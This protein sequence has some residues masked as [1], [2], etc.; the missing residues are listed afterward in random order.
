MLKITLLYDGSAG[1]FHENIKQLDFWP[2]GQKCVHDEPPITKEK[3]KISDCPIPVLV[4]ADFLPHLHKRMV[5]VKFSNLFC[6][7]LIVK[8][9]LL[10]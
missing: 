1:I 9:I 7:I 10:H 5:A 6:K 4:M 3:I 8:L 2:D